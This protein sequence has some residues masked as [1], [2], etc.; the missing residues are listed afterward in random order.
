MKTEKK[1]C[2]QGGKKMRAE[3]QKT[4]PEE[5]KCEH[6]C[7]RNQNNCRQTQV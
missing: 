4:S 7:R 2:D 6:T 3:L 5:G 1:K